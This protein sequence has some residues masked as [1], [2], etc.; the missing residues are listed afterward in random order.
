MGMDVYGLDPQVN[1]V[2]ESLYSVYLTYKDM[3][4]DEKWKELDK[5]K[6]LREKYWEQKHAFEDLNP[7]AYF[8]NNVW[9]WRPLWHYVCQ[10]CDD[11]L[12]SED[13]D[14]CTDNSGYQIDTDKALRIGIR[15]HALVLDGSTQEWKEG[16]DKEVAEL[17]KEPCFRCNGN[18]HGHA[19]KK[20]CK[21]CDKTGERE[22]FQ[23]NYPFDVENVKAFAT[24]CVESGGFEVC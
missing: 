22:N 3:D 19:K 13:M 6:D 18:N 11:I 8:R 10:V 23:A 4:F 16:Y 2:D 20:D 24:F 5:D 1:T 9:W 12:T 17:P 7:G 21:S 15:L 14:G